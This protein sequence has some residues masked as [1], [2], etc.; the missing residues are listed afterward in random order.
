MAYRKGKMRI[1]KEAGGLVHC[2]LPVQMLDPDGNPGEM[3]TLT[4][5]GYR[6]RLASGRTRRWG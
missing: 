4:G 1:L 2:R 5:P 3:R 6:N